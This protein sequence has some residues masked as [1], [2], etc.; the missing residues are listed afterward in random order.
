M[1]RFQADMDSAAI[2]LL[3][4]SFSRP[5]MAIAGQILG[6][7]ASAEDAVQ[8]AFLR[9]VRQRMQYDAG[10]LFSGWFYAILRNVCIDIK[11]RQ[12]RHR[13][14]I[15]EYAARITDTAIPLEHGQ[16]EFPDLMNRLPRGERDVLVLRIVHEMAFADIAASL[17]I[18][19]EAA[20]KRAQRGLRRLREK[21]RHLDSPKERIEFMSPAS[22][23]ERM[24][25]RQAV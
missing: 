21:A 14:A 3:V 9:V 23:F 24:V 6:A 2:E 1:S 13:A 4:S 18:A 22:H 8:E 15:T 11:R 10:R 25:N 7:N 17:G 12:A 16:S 19:E 5:A 20:K